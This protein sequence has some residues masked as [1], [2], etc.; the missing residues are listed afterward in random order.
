[1]QILN[2]TPFIAA[3]LPG[4]L[5]F[6]GHSLTLIVKGT[7]DL[8]LEG[9]TVIAQDPLYPAGDEYYP[10]DED[11]RGALRYPS[12]FAYFKPRADLLLVGT[13]YAPGGKPVNRCRVVFQVGERRGVLALSGDRTWQHTEPAP[14]ARMPLGYERS[15]GGA[16]CPENP[17]GLGF[18]AVNGPDGRPAGP[19]P[20][21]ENP[22]ALLR[23]PSQRPEPA[24]FGPL[25]HAWAGRRALLG[26]YDGDY[27]ESRWPWFARDFDWGYFNAAPPGMQVE[28]YLRGDEPLYFENLRPEVSQLHAALPGLR[29]RCFVD[30][31]DTSTTPGGFRELPMR[32]DTLWVDMDA[33]R[34]VLVWRGPAK[35]ESEEAAEIRHVFVVA[36][37][38]SASSMPAEHYRS[39]FERRLNELEQ[40]G[41]I[42]P[43]E[44]EPAQA[45]EPP[46]AAPDEEIAQ[47]EAALR[48]RLAA[49][50]ID[51]TDLPPP[52]EKTL[53]REAQ[54]LEA[55][56]FETEAPQADTMTRADVEA[57]AAARESLANRD[58]S[59]LDLSELA[60]EGVDLR[61]A[62]LTGA[63]LRNA[64]LSHAKLG[65]ANM[66]G[67]D[68]GD[69]QLRDADLRGAD[70]E[71]SRLDGADLTGAKL[72]GAN[73]EGA[74][75]AGANLSGADS[76]GAWFIAADLTGAR[77]P[78]AN[79][80][81][82]DFSNAT[83][84]RADFRGCLLHEA[85]FEGA[86]GRR[87]DFS[88]ADLAELRAGGCDFSHG[89]FL[90][91]Q[92]ADSIWAEAKLGGANF[93]YARLEGADF[94]GA[95]V[96]GADLFAADLRFARLTK[97]LLTDARLAQANLFQ[98]SLEKADLTGANLSGSNLYG[99]E[100]LDA[101][102]IETKLDGANLKMSK[103]A[104]AAV[105]GASGGV[106]DADA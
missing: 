99:A 101:K 62:N 85:S 25:N 4:R 17:L 56:G 41:E 30:R 10:G 81:G 15:F 69:A 50:G 3:P 80:A 2:D 22:G 13:C 90:Q 20:N 11:M 97:A 58:L 78:R 27:L 60:L 37:D 48:E 12:D 92:G 104:R 14:F 74:R 19:L 54:L 47:A 9:K 84:E 29:V 87:I 96:N 36:E 6:P 83:L 44:P 8:T 86:A 53:E 1:L 98:A 43:A 95:F 55:L 77:A 67:A 21:I 71:G 66:A 42:E 46:L 24:G 35:V 59:A 31:A 57:R 33:L 102:L 23:T 106:D 38:L 68:F 45:E 79:F 70:L 94:T 65:G 52:D 7:F 51:P 49:A 63:N 5:S 91:A 100:T 39:L 88:G 75:M 82:A 26:R 89:V 72:S 61:N 105:R 34:L 40:E 32:L 64:K 93:R 18:E 73:F 16:S 103:L 76:D 28:G